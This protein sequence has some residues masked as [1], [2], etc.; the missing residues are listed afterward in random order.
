MSVCV[1]GLCVW[2]GFVWEG[3]VCIPSPEEVHFSAFFE[4]RDAPVRASYQHA[5]VILVLGRK[6]MAAIAG[7][8]AGPLCELEL[9]LGTRETSELPVLLHQVGLVVCWLR[10][11]PGVH[12]HHATHI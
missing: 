7:Q 5:V 12:V 1:E 8:L 9:S 10:G 6:E 4:D 2:E 11:R 3:V